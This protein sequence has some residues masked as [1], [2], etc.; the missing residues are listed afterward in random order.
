ML[1]EWVARPKLLS[2][3]RR[4]R[5]TIA[6]LVILAAASTGFL[7]SRL[8]PLPISPAPKLK[9]AASDAIAFNRDAPTKQMDIRSA[10]RAWT[11]GNVPVTK[12]ERADATEKPPGA[13][14]VLLNPGTAEQPRSVEERAQQSTANRS[15]GSAEQP[16]PATQPAARPRDAKVASPQVARNQKKHRAEPNSAQP[17]PSSTGYQRDTAMRDFMSHNPPFTR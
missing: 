2:A 4:V 11:D 17:A 3:D 1:Q 5:G 14:L 15:D 9:V 10:S 12:S 8:W 13:S 6:A 16:M 7:A